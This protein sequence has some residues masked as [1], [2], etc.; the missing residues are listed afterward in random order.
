MYLTRRPEYASI[1]TRLKAGDSFLDVGCCFGQV[2][3]QLAFDG[4]PA[5]NLAGT[6]LRREFIDLGY[7]LFRDDPTRFPAKFATGDIFEPNDASMESLD[8]GYDVIHAASF[9][10]LFSWDEQVRVG[11]RMVRFL[12]PGAKGMVLGRQ[13]GTRQPATDAG[14]RYVHNVE[15]F[16]K[17]WDTIGEKTGTKWKVTGEVRDSETVWVSRALL[18]FTVTQVL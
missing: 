1:I 11:E 9:F 16:Q 12:K 8:G 4:A 5:A 15:S 6:D 2:L 7:S 10:H 13:V 17:L 3:R 18:E 14:G